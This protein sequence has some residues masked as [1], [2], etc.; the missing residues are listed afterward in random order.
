VG[1]DLKH[2]PIRK[3]EKDEKH[4][5]RIRCTEWRQKPHPAADHG[6]DAGSPRNGGCIKSRSRTHPD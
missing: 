6:N 2:C 1:H 3:N 4:E 5:A